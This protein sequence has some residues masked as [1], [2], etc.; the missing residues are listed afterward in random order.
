[1]LKVHLVNVEENLE[2]LILPEMSVYSDKGMNDQQKLERI[3]DDLKN[4]KGCRM[5]GFF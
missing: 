1:M 3:K 4:K 5:K 2:K